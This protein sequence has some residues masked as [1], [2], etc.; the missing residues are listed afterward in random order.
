MAKHTLARRRPT[1]AFHKPW[2][3]RPLA[4]ATLL[5]LVVGCGG[6]TPDDADASDNSST[7]AS[8]S[9]A[10]DDPALQKWRA[11]VAAQY[12]ITDPPHVEPVKTVLPEEATAYI[13]ACMKDKGFASTGAG[14][15]SYPVDQ[16]EAFNLA[17]YECTVAYPPDPAYLQPFTEVQMG[18]IYD[19][20]IETE[21]PC[22]ESEGYTVTGVPSKEVFIQTFSTDPFWP[23]E[24]VTEQLLAQGKGEA[25][26]AALEEKCP[27]TPPSDVLYG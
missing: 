11:D 26:L 22:L 27:Q 24:Q 20:M 12:G 10:Q 13:D 19:F 4:A 2:V 6:Q 23:Y 14:A 18:R 8:H 21:I 1:T 5:F 17:R 25:A 15:Y 3:G 7:A 16:Q 9:N